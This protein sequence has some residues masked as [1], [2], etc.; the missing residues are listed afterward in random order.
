MIHESAS[1]VGDSCYG[2]GADDGFWAAMRLSCKTMTSPPPKKAPANAQFIEVY[3][4][5]EANGSLY[6]LTCKSRWVG[7][8][9]AWLMPDEM[10]PAETQDWRMRVSFPKPEGK[11]K[12]IVRKYR[13]VDIRPRT[14]PPSPAPDQE[15][16]PEPSSG[17]YSGVVRNIA[18]GIAVHFGVS[19]REENGTIAGCMLVRPPLYGSGAIRGA[20]RGTEVSFD[21]VGPTFILR[22]RGELQGG[23]WKGTYA[24]APNTED[25]VFDLRRRSSEA[26]ASGIGLQE[27]L[28]KLA[29]I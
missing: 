3:N 12:G 1:T 18:S 11:R 23:E 20:V 24:I 15:P 4:L 29:G 17:V 16:K 19:I 8:G 7:R 9:C 10:L 25:G 27:C 28:G 6:A 26:P 22:F 14:A 2:G 5:V 21:D 13:L